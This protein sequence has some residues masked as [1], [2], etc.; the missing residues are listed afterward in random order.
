M[1]FHP[2]IE[3]ALNRIGILGSAASDEL[4]VIL[5]ENFE[6]M[7]KLSMESITDPK[8]FKKALDKERAAEIKKRQQAAEGVEL[9]SL[10]VRDLDIQKSSDDD[11][12]SENDNETEESEESRSG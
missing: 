9:I 1:P 6:E 7:I 12:D 3:F 5:D 8:K 2:R 4:K 10:S 11:D